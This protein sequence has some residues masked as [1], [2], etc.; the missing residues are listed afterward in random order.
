MWRRGSQMDEAGRRLIQR[1]LRVNH[2]GEHGAISIYRAQMAVAQ[3]RYPELIPWLKDTLS[4][5][6]SHRAKF[7]AAMPE[8]RAKPCRALFIWSIGG[9]VLGT[10]TAW[11]GRGGI[12]ACTSA[13]ERTVQRHLQ[14]QIHFLSSRDAAL[15]AVVRD[16]QS[17]ENAHL[18]HADRH[19][20][21]TSF[22]SRIVTWIVSAATETMI[23]LS[24]RG[25][26]LRLARDLKSAAA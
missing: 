20:D 24:T 3:R 12:M 7:Y 4:H 13:V 14:E 6:T 23:F 8:R 18:D 5:E 16:V 2:A 10:I 25:D 17:E 22:V 11:M 15:A 1:I 9:A 26:S 21:G 19:H